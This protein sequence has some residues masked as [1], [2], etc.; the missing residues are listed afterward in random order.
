MESVN[1]RTQEV[2]PASEGVQRPK[3]KARMDDEVS[4][5]GKH[6]QFV[7]PTP[8]GL[9]NGLQPSPS[10]DS[11][12]DEPT[13]NNDPPSN[14]GAVS[15]ADTV[16]PSDFKEEKEKEQVHKSAQHPHP[17]EDIIKAM[18]AELSRA[19]AN[20]IEGEILCLRAMFPNYAGEM[21]QDPLSI[22]KATSGPDTMY[23]HEAMQE[24]D[25][26]EERMQKS[27]QQWKF[28]CGRSIA[29]SRGRHNITSGVANEKK[30][31]Y[32]DKKDQEVQS[33]IEH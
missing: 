27:N 8:D 29:G 1:P 31:R 12:M 4:K 25:S 20:D 2:L 6:T 7:M 10:N 15:D 24:N 32:Q 23:M 18:K 9:D 3:K 16:R 13:N 26:H 19:T 5:P 17:A 30:K 11:Q 28:Q 33:N 21:E 14:P 22:Y